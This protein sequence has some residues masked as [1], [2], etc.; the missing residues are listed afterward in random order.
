MTGI[1][2]PCYIAAVAT[3]S[4]TTLT[5]LPGGPLASGLPSGFSYWGTANPST[6]THHASSS[7]LGLN[8]LRPANDN[9]LHE[10]YI[11]VRYKRE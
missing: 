2:C 8:E 10:M 4:G 6:I 9:V 3:T 7:I 11:P 5:L 1:A